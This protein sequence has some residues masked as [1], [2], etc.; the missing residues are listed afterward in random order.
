M[1]I[2]DSSARHHGR[3]LLFHSIDIICQTLVYGIY[4]L[5]FPVSTYTMVRKGVRAPARKLLLATTTGMFVLSTLFWGLS[6]TSFLQYVI[7][8]FVEDSTMAGA[9]PGYILLVNSLVLINYLISDAVVVWRAWLLCREESKG[10][11]MMSML[12]LACSALAFLAVLGNRIFMMTIPASDPRQVALSRTIDIFQVGNLVFSLITN[13]IA[14]STVGW[15]AWR[16]R[17]EI[18]ADIADTVNRGSVAGKV[19]ILLIESGALYIVSLSV[20]LPAMLIRLPY[21]TVGDIYIPMNVQMSG[22]YPTVIIFLVNRESS[23]DKAVFNVSRISSIIDVQRAVPAFRMSIHDVSAPGSV[24]HTTRHSH[25]TDLS[26]DTRH[27]D[28]VC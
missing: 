16:R 9:L 27:G 14:T 5:V 11:L 25:G 13:I 2:T 10:L 7:G 21:G 3:W 26:F 1:I 17:K 6:V 8:W 20:L 19:L 23:M 22:I 28:A 24:Q 12:F 4:V 18:T 15:K